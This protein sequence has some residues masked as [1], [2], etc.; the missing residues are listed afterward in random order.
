MEDVVD[1]HLAAM[2][3]KLENCTRRQERLKILQD[4][5]E[6]KEK[7]EGL[8]EE[9]NLKKEIKVKTSEIK[10]HERKVNSTNTL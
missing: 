1:E 2:N 4:I 10:S 8:N 3:E 9:D 6:Y 5:K 7:V